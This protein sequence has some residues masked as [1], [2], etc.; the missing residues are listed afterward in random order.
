M[1]GLAA[2]LP[3]WIDVSLR[4]KLIL[5][6]LV[7]LVLGSGIFL[8]ALISLYRDRLMEDRSTAASQVYT[9]L[10]AALENAMLKRDIDGLRDIVQR[11]GEQSDIDRV[12]ILEP[13]GEVRFASKTSDLGRHFDLEGA[14]LCAGCALGP[15]DLEAIT[16]FVERE[17]ADDLLRSV[18]PV[19]N[20][21]PCKD[22][23]GSHEEH[24]VNGV[25]VVDYLGGGIRE[26]ALR[27][28][29]LMSV[30]GIIVIGMA[31]LGLWLG[32]EAWLLRPLTALGDSSVRL[33]A[34]DLASR[35]DPDG[36]DEIAMLGRAFD[37]MAGQI[38]CNVEDLQ[39][40]ERF[41]QALIDAIP[42]GIRV[43][44]PDFRVERA[45]RAFLEQQGMSAEEVIG[46]P[47]HQS[48]HRLEEPCAPTLVTCPLHELSQGKGALICRH[49][50]IGADE[51]EL[52][53][54]VSAAALEASEGS[55]GRRLVVESIRDLSKEI[56]LS[57]EH[58]L[59]ELGMLAAGVAHE[60]YNPLTSI[61]FVLRSIQSLER[62]ELSADTRRDYLK[63]MDEEV[64]KCIKITDRLLKLSV[65]RSSQP[66]LVDLAA[67]LPE[68]TSLLGA[69]ADAKSVRLALELEPRLRIIGG[70]SEMRMLAL[71]LAQNALH[72]MPDGGRL[73]IRGMVDNGE[74]VL[75]FADSGVGIATADL[76]RVFHPF[77]SR[78]ADRE[79]RSGTGL[80]LS[81]CRAIVQSHN[82]SVSVQSELG[83]GT[84]VT[85]RLPEADAE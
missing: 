81:I 46:Q 85:V 29:L 33:A 10:H 8:A 5:V 35:V 28:A 60:I 54:E 1:S 83:K 61:R 57:H 84:V 16:A 47:C 69:E 74:V 59:S 76:E 71:N 78:R 32:L 72:A 20:R 17:D 80:G 21:E 40:R 38:E 6:L 41:L 11:L 66:M 24:P 30:A 62:G 53:V 14:E 67:L 3:A 56:H 37:G 48:S 52:F 75:S 43:I 13:G 18:V 26:A 44:G 19:A 65:P 58:K 4:R 55:G 42:D 68:V 7:S 25:L 22:C 9:L 50:H 31:V 82:G 36:R 15:G 45:N 79:G 70:D 49:R 63:L 34:G 27:G 64:E 23:H 2:A 73:V 12:M 51:R 77:W 39:T